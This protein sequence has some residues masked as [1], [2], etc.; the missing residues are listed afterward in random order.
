MIAMQDFFNF[1]EQK[2]L[3]K[4]DGVGRLLIPTMNQPPGELC[5]VINL[6]KS[7]NK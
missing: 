1:M 6:C 2:P 4:T 7:E 3:P 5:M